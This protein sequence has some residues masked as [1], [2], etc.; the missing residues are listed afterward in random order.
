MVT[1]GLGENL[2]ELFLYKTTGSH[3]CPML[4]CTI[5]TDRSRFLE[6]LARNG[7]IFFF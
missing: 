1:S 2:G 6:Q 7:R 5:S 4:Y 3:A